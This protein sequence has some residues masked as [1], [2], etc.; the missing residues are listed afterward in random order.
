MLKLIGRLVLLLGRWKADPRMPYE[1]KHL[2]VI[3]SPHTTNWDL[4]WMLAVA[5]ATGIRLRW[6][7]KDAL[8]R[9]WRGPIMRLLGG[10][11][12][13]RS[14]TNN[15]VEASAAEFAKHESLWMAVPAA[16]TRSKRDYWKSGFY[17]IARTAG[18]PIACGYLDYPNRIGGINT[19]V[20]P[21]DDLVADMDKIRDFYKDIGGK[22]PDKVT[23]IRLRAEDEPEQQDA[24]AGDA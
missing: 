4:V 9:G 2:V 13:D 8:F 22:Y 1:H 12:I 16:G 21:T 3:A 15:V 17:W 23:R 10:I 11:A 19:V 24:P 18:V 7:G 5:W 20:V 6:M 14:K